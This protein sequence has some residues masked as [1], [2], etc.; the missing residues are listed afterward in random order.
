MYIA[1]FIIQK[2]FKFAK[3]KYFNTVQKSILNCVNDSNFVHIYFQ[4][5]SNIHKYDRM[6]THN[7]I[8]LFHLETNNYTNDIYAANECYKR[9]VDIGYN[10]HWIIKLRPDLLV[11]DANIFKNLRFKYNPSF[12][13]A[14]SRFYV[15][16]LELKKHQTSNWNRYSNI[17]HSQS[18]LLIADIQL[19]M[20]PYHLQ[21]FAFKA[22]ELV[23]THS[24]SNGQYE[25]L[26]NVPLNTITIHDMKQ[27][28]EKTQT[29]LW[30]HF[31]IPINIAEFYVVL[32]QDMN[33]YNLSNF[34]TG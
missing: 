21:T 26:N 11:F 1:F 24:V 29:L 16:P 10:Y 3:D 15:G 4:S 8:E 31:N 9:C 34:P 2:N 25:N 6:F 32:F 33:L 22:Q 18:R 12:I 23:D 17:H 28:E 13:H 30:K 19:Y 7:R 14:R 5:E 20:I 27:S